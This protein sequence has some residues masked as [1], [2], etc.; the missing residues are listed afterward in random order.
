MQ[1]K[2][3]QTLAIAS[4]KTSVLLKKRSEWL[5]MRSRR[6]EVHLLVAASYVNRFLHL[7]NPGLAAHSHLRRCY[8]DAQRANCLATRLSRQLEPPS[9]LSL[10]RLR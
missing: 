10:D 8:T 3:R 9:D 2:P 4:H 1:V 7:R 5:P 6:S